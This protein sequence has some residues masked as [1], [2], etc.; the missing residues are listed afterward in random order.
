MIDIS[1][2]L[3][4]VQTQVFIIAFVSWAI[5]LAMAP[6]V[7][8]V[9]D[10]L[11]EEDYAYLALGKRGVRIIDISS[12]DDPVEVGEYDT[13]GEANALALK[14]DSLFVADGRGGL[15]ALTM[16][17]NKN[18]SL[19]WV[20]EKSKSARDVT[21][22]ENY[23]F[24]ADA[25][26]GVLVVKTDQSPDD[27]WSVDGVGGMV[28]LVADGDK[29][30]GVGV[31]DHFYVFNI[32]K[33]KKAKEITSFALKTRVNNVELQGS[34][35]YLATQKRGLLWVDNPNDQTASPTGET[36]KFGKAIQ[37]IVLAGNYAYIGTGVSS[38]KLGE[39]HDE[40]HPI[41]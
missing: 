33:P 4:K 13:Y 15:L 10:I 28:H 11:I 14:G 39:A 8:D 7:E 5:F 1:A 9:N 22:R 19:R 17:D 12:P 23:A 31:D 6:A 37:A 27:H 18:L 35:V 32:K 30:Y 29:A 34:R 21:I 3:K 38:Q 26:R 41:G 20:F 16:D 40:P 2:L 25:E 24:V 36:E